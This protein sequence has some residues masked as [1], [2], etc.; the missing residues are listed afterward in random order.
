[1]LEYLVFFIILC[2]N[3]SMIDSF[4]TPESHQPPETEKKLSALLTET[5]DLLYPTTGFSLELDGVHPTPLAKKE[6]EAFS[7]LELSDTKGASIT[8]A[9]NIE[10]DTFELESFA[11]ALKNQSDASF[12]IHKTT[13]P[14]DGLQYIPFAQF[15]SAQ[16]DISQ[17]SK[18]R[19]LTNDTLASFLAGYHLS[20][21]PHPT[22]ESYQ[23]W[24]A[25]LLSNC[26]KGW[27]TTESTTLITG[28][29]ESTEETIQVRKEIYYQDGGDIYSRHEIVHS[30]ILNDP[31]ESPSVQIVSTAL[32]E[33]ID[34]FGKSIH[35]VKRVTHEEHHPFV[36]GYVEKSEDVY[37]EDAPLD[38]KTLATFTRMSN[39]AKDLLKR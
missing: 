28:V 22:H 12:M 29:S 33:E 6:L 9:Y 34:P 19:A 10:S 8:L 23:L 31:R 24:R 4:T 14:R 38:E 17:S 20:H 35:A 30:N 11:H 5:C 26:Q 2:Y 37:I 1:M 25:D 27:K 39:T 36:Y 3:I 21:I 7:G 15:E 13:D 16:Y 32:D 18:N